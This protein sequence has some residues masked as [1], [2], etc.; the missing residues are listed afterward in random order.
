MTAEPGTTSARSPHAESGVL[1][2]SAWRPWA[3][4]HAARV[5]ALV[6]E[7]L[8]RR[9]RG[10]KHPVEDFLWT[11]YRVRPGVLRR[12]YPGPGVVL[13][14]ASERAEWRY[15]RVVA[16]GVELD[17]PTYAAERGDTVAFVRRLLA[18]TLSRRG[19]WSCFGLHE[20][21][22]VY[23]SGESGTRHDWPLRL[24]DRGTD[25]VVESHQLKCTHHDAFR[26]FTSDAVGLNVGV[27]TREGQVAQEQPGCLHAGM[28]L[29]K[30]AGK[31]GPGVPGEL[32]LDAFDLAHDARE[33]D[34]RAAPYDLRALGYEP[35]AIETPA[36]KAEYVEHQRALAAR[37]AV[38][39][40]RL[41]DV[42]DLLLA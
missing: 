20:W 36:G 31:L 22:M 18:A 24:G 19:Q 37:A 26:F 16:G 21:A 17:L 32:L 34:M 12:W 25:E 28:D 33:L 15:H 9:R 5:D 8:D 1:Q 29:Y 27:P 30:W 11:Y 39:R 14:G 42:C 41:I 7:H 40:R 13:A 38:L 23:R 4:A 10:V 2:E 3:D 35:I 6:A